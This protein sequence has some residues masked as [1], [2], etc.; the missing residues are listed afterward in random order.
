MIGI[1]VS[2]SIYS[3]VEITTEALHISMDD[4]NSVYGHGFFSQKH[5]Q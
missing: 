5:F 4:R 2:E 1:S 3:R